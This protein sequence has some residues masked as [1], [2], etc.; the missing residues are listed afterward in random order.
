MTFDASETEQQITHSMGAMLLLHASNQ[1]LIEVSITPSNSP[2]YKEL[3][4][5]LGAAENL[6]LEWRQNGFLY[7]QQEILQQVVS[8]GQSFVGQQTRIDGLFAKLE[9]NFSDAAKQAIVDAM[10]ALEAPVNSMISQIGANLAKLKT[11]E[12]GMQGPYSRMNTTVAR[13][14]AEAVKIQSEINTI[15]AKI[16]SLKQQIIADRTAIAKAKKARDRGILETIFGI[17]LAPFTG[18]VSLILAGIG[19]GTIAEAEEKVHQLESTI[20]SYQASIANDQQDLSSDEKQ[21]AT[22]KGLTMSVEIALNDMAEIEAALDSLRTTWN[23]LLG[24]VQDAV[25]DVQ[26]SDTAKDAIVSQVWFDAACTTWQDVIAF[27]KQLAANNA[28]TPHH[29]TVGGT[30]PPSGSG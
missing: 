9:A 30:S 12:E 1:A 15:N 2:W 21:I 3:N 28:P 23:F 18:G 25:K 22:L 8:C 4:D 27:A 24:S 13:I 10:T 20:A 19:V 11:F 14:Q 5:E 7:F 26:R 6:V 16:E 17:L 29:V